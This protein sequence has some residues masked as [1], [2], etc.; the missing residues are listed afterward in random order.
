MRRLR[1]GR[2]RIL[3]PGRARLSELPPPSAVGLTDSEN[4]DWFAPRVGFALAERRMACRSTA[5]SRA[6]SSRRTSASLSPTTGGFQPL[7]EQDAWTAEIGTRGRAGN[8]VW[9]VALYRAEI[10]NELLTFSVNPGLGIPAATFNALDG[11]MHQ[12]IEAGLDWE[13]IDGLRLRQTYMWSDFR[14]T[15]D[16]SMATTACRSCRSTSI[17]PSCK[18]TTSAA[19]GSRRRSSGRCRMRGSTT[20]TRS[21]R[22]PTASSTSTSAT[23]SRTGR[24]CSSMSA[25]SL[26]EN[27]V[28]NFT[29]VVNWNTPTA[30]QRN[31]FF[32]GDAAI[33]LRRRGVH[34]L[35]GRTMA[36]AVEA[37]ET[38][39]RGSLYR[40]LWRWHFYAGLIC[41]PFVIWLAVTGSIYLFRPQIDAWV[42]R[43]V[44]VLERT[45]EPATPA[46]D[47]S[48]RLRRPCRARRFAGHHAAR[49][50]GPG[51]ARAGVRQWRPHARLRASR[52]AGGPEDAVDEGSTLGSLDLQAARRADDGQR[53]A[54]SWSSSPPRGRS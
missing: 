40:M 4:Y 27:Y 49:T 35:R 37:R 7:Q 5:T 46:G 1:A 34:V 33:R 22:R 19:S 17:A 44:A 24:C 50:A 48:R 39:G 43:D 41:I 16:G 32:P 12:G 36:S 3:R 21:R 14:F 53:R 42:D 26:D 38:E 9:D 30:A 25:T 47:S 15:D 51:G 23:S 2:R 28:S 20:P 31:V 18:W 52:Y 29:A 8:F 13:I 6:R 11:T 10:D 45:G 54:R